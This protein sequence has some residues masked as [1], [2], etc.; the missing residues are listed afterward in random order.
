MIKKKQKQQA[1][2]LKGLTLSGGEPFCQAEACA[3]LAEPVKALGLDVVTYSGY[4]YEQLIERRDPG[5]DALI[6]ATD[7]LVDGPFIEALRDVSL[8][9]R[10]S[11]N[12]RI[13][14]MNQT[15]AKGAPIFVE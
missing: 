14:D 1:H 13:I 11:G 15:R 5:T 3:R 2:Y 4:T 8:K 6:R 9:F 12:Q 10:G 7:I